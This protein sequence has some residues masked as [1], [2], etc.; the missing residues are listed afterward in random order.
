MTP[1]DETAIPNRSIPRAS[2]LRDA[3]S[4]A[5]DGSNETNALFVAYVEE[6][7][8]YHAPNE[9][10]RVAYDEINAAAKFFALAV[11]RNCP[12]CADR[13]DAIRQIRMARMTANASIATRGQA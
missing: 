5:R 6:A 11:F 7:F 2:F 3:L 1:T 10:Q 4:V 9:A 12:P 13:S 8:T